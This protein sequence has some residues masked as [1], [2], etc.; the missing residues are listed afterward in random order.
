LE[1]LRG[2]YGMRKKYGREKLTLAEIGG[3]RAVVGRLIRWAPFGG[4]ERQN[5]LQKLRISERLVILLE[6]IEEAH[7]AGFTTR[8][9]KSSFHSLLTFSSF[10]GRVPLGKV[11]H[12]VVTHLLLSC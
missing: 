8:L 4:E 9:L 6:V 3:K 11:V 7:S 10:F 1:S 5:Q 2:N 12:H